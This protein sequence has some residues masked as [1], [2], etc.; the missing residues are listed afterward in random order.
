MRY[1]NRRRLLIV[2]V[3]AA[4]FG[5]VLP[6]VEMLGTHLLPFSREREDP[7]RERAYH[8]TRR[9]TIWDE[10]IHVFVDGESPIDRSAE[11]ERRYGV[12]IP[13]G[14]RQ[15]LMAGDSFM[16]FKFGWP[17]RAV[18]YHLWDQI[19]MG[20]EYGDDA[21]VLP[22]NRPK[23]IVPDV[24]PKQVIWKGMLGNVVISAIFFAAMY[25]G[26]AEMRARRRINRG[27][28]WKCGYQSNGAAVCPECGVGVKA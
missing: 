3:L 18:R 25:I 5:A 28:C 4:L 27:K 14:A 11:L 8:A 23:W 22:R 17:F 12:L 6:Y 21:I 24:I 2:V 26:M 19:N 15:R 7:S 13:A 10:S 9:S 1:V 20:F 16:Q